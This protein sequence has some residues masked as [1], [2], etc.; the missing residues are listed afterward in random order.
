MTTQDTYWSEPKYQ[1][2]NALD[3]WHHLSAL[4]HGKFSKP[5]CVLQQTHG[6]GCAVSLLSTALYITFY[7]LNVSSM[8]WH[9]QCKHVLFLTCFLTLVSDIY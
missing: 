3:Q 8:A 6:S 4:A 2:D 5:A 1:A 7:S 9:M